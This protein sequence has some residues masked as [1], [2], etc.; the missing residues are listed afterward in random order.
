MREDIVR[1][2]TDAPDTCILIG[3]AHMPKDGQPRVYDNNTRVSL[4]RYLHYRLTGEYPPADVWL[5]PG[6][7]RT[8]KCQ[9]PN[10]RIP[11]P[12]LMKDHNEPA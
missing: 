9:N 8:V 12:R 5:H 4:P 11:G 2:L 1:T 3:A 7:C 6:G 10:H